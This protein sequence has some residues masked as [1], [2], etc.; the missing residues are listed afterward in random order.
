MRTLTNT[1][2]AL[3]IVLPSIA[4]A[5]NTATETS[6]APKQT[7]SSDILGG[8][9]AKVFYA[10]YVPNS[11]TTYRIKEVDLKETCANNH[12]MFSW[13]DGGT[14]GPQGPKGDPGP[15]GVPGPKG[16][17]GV[18]GF[19]Q[20]QLVDGSTVTVD[21]GDVG[22]ADAF[23]PAGWTATGGGYFVVSYSGL[24]PP[25]MITNTGG[26]NAWTA[27][28]TNAVPGAQGP[29]KFHARVICAK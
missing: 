25:V 28:L 1:L 13:T 14:P 21:V 29:V 6:R 7:V 10:C 27:A 24:V 18:S 26:G 16:D 12:V 5:Q 4:A 22:T 19:T 8:Q 11:G 20:V 3:A 2:V 23:C 17:P 9:P 15:Q